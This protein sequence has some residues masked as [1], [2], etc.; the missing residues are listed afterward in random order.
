[1]GDGITN[2]QIEN[3]FLKDENEDL[4]RNFIGVFSMDY[5]TRF[6]KFH[7]LLKR[8]RKANTP[9]QYL[10]PTLITNQGC[11]GGVF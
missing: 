1:M 10:I 7:N 11:I 2:S 8:K 9:S 4:K 3:F 5:I 6:I